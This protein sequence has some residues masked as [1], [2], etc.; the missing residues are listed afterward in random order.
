MKFSRLLGVA[1]TGGALFGGDLVQ[2]QINY[3]N[4]QG[5]YPSATPAL[6]TPSVT[7]PINYPL[8]NNS[9]YSVASMPGGN[10]QFAGPTNAPV[11]RLPSGSSPTMLGLSSATGSG[12]AT[13]PAMNSVLTNSPTTPVGPVPQANIGPITGPTYQDQGIGTR[14]P[15]YTGLGYGA[16]T[17]GDK[18]VMPADMAG[19]K[20]SDMTGA[21]KFQPFQGDCTSG[22]YVGPNG[23]YGG[24]YGMVLS[25]DTQNHYTFSYDTANESVQHTDAKDAQLDWNGGFAAVFGH[26]FNCGQNAIEAV[27]WGWYPEEASVLTYGTDMVGGLSGIFNWDSLT[28]DGQNMGVG[29][30]DNAAVHGLFRESELHNVEVNVLS[31]SQGTSSLHYTL[32]AGWRY[33]RFRDQLVFR[34][35]PNDTAFTGEADEIFYDMSTTNDLIG[36]QIGGVGT[37]M[38]GPRLSLNGGTKV[39]FFGNHISHTSHI[40]G[41]AGTAVINNGP[42]SGLEFLVDNSKTDV[43]FLTEVFF[44]MGYA[45]NSRWSASAGYRAVAVTG[46]ALPTDQIYPDLRGIN[47]L[48]TVESQS[49]MI[50]HGAYFGGQFTF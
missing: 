30:V 14:Q 49:S 50:L 32:L 22:C 26:Y 2:A 21:S 34:A 31:F 11:T 28:Y 18:G 43:S 8:P 10:P 13:G 39:G 3:R 23:W 24:L 48:Y 41:A 36:F 45:I 15:T 19:P 47:D 20:T 9:H 42:N 5:T 27:Y 35:D 7:Y 38:V 17:Q 6:V 44:G 40:G 33:F 12:Q 16:P 29:Y 25:R 37:Y 1:V 4:Y 46:L